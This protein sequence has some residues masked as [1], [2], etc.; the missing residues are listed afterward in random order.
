MHQ[1]LTDMG[2]YEQPFPTKTNTS[3]NNEDMEK[4]LSIITKLSKHSYPEKDTEYK[5]VQEE[6][7]TRPKTTVV[8]INRQQQMKEIDPTEERNA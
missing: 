3:S 5:E 4:M 2:Y 6:Q 8:K 7:L 1:A